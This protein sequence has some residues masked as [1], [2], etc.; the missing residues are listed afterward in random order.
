MDRL[1]LGR[2]GI[3]YNIMKVGNSSYTLKFQIS[4]SGV[5]PQPHRM[6]QPN[7]CAFK[8]CDIPVVSKEAMA[9]EKVQGNVVYVLVNVILLL[10]DTSI[11]YICHQ[12][13][14]KLVCHSSSKKSLHLGLC[15][16]FSYL[17][18]IKFWFIDICQNN[19]DEI[20]I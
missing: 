9:P 1:M 12:V 7:N 10:S 19:E 13:N 6:S 20:R 14:H 17:F 3:R 2:V 8:Q 15:I 5:V 16:C 4:T 11:S 18:L